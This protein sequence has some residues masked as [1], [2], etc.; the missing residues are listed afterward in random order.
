M[1]STEKVK[2]SVNML[3]ADVGT[4]EDIANQRG[5]TKTEA[6]R[7]AIATEKFLRDAVAKGAEILIK[8]PKDGSLQRLV[9]R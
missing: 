5:T 9:I 7:G 2:V 3:P 8:D 1:D 6:L 4:L